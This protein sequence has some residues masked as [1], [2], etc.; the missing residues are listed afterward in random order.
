MAG[1]DARGG[2]PG[3]RRAG[4][5]RL[6]ARP[7][8]PGRALAREAL[9][10]DGSPST[11]AKAMTYLGSVAQRPG[12]LPAGRRAARRGH[13]LSRAAERAAARGVRPGD[14][15]RVS[16]LRG[17]LDDAAADRLR[18]A[19]DAG[20]A[21]PLARRSCPGRRRCSGRCCSRAVTSRGAAEALEQSFAR[22]CQI[23]DPCWEGISARGLALL[24]RRHGDA[25]AAFPSSLDA[26]AAGQP[27]RRPLRRGSTCTSS[28]RSASSAV[29]TGTRD[30]PA[31]VEEMHRRASRTG[32][33]ELT[34]RAML[35]GAALGDRRGRGGRRAP[36]RR[37]RQP[38]ADA[39]HPPTVELT[40]SAGSSSASRSSSGRCRPTPRCSSHSSPDMAPSRSSSASS[41]SSSW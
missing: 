36:G 7:L 9:A 27:A 26:R 25:D 23:G 20:R 41:R 40:S 34:V 4:V 17:E 19:V 11:R 12:G 16:L 15:G 38:G 13:R 33:R 18:R 22:A 32:M 21:R 30:T 37:H 10:R 39:A 35:H 29:A 6:P 31:W 24:R 28:T 8:R 5:R 3:P 1:G 2:G 14:A